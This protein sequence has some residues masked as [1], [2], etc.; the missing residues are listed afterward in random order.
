[1]TEQDDLWT[2]IHFNFIKMYC[3]VIILLFHTAW[4]PISRPVLYCSAVPL[5]QH[6][7]QDKRP[8]P[9]RRGH[10]TDPQYSDISP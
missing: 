9:L 7:I 10:K 5:Q 2:L 8:P 1:M 4:L 6:S 3:L